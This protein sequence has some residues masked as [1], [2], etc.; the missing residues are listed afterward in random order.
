LKLRIALASAALVALA[1]PFA[2][3]AG[4]PTDRATGGGQ[5]LIG[6]RGGAGDTIAF[7]AQDRETNPGQVQYIDRTAEGQTRYH[8]TVAC[9]MVMENVAY[10]GGTWEEQ[11]AGNFNLYVEDNGE[12]ANAAGADMIFIDEAADNPMCDFDEP[13]D[14]DQLDLAR[15]NAQVYDADGGEQEASAAEAAGLSFLSL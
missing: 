15:G 3:S 6:T 2:A 12:G 13:E 10:I 11:G 7:T 4:S 14:E 8:G 9:L 1:L 5:V